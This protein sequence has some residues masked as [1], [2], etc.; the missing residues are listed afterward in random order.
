MSLDD[1][2]RSTNRRRTNRR[3]AAAF[4]DSGPRPVVSRDAAAAERVRTDKTD[5]E[6]ADDDGMPGRMAK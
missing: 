5:S 6:R 1:D 3:I 2:R 4:T